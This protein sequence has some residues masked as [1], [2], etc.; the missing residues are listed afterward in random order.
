MTPGP[1]LHGWFTATARRSP[2]R[3]AVNEPGREPITYAR[4]EALSG[5]V[6]DR[7]LAEGL[8]PGD[9]VGIYLTKSVDA[10]AA[11][12]GALR[13][14]AA[15]VPIDPGSPAW[16]ADFILNDCAVQALV[17]ERRFLDGLETLRAR[18][19]PPVVIALDEV[20]DGRGLAAVLGDRRVPGGDDA[21][22]EADALAYILYTSGSTGKP[23]GVMVSHRAAM[24][25]VDW[26]SRAFSPVPDDRFSSHAPF[27]FDLSIL[28]LYLPLRH[29]ARVTLIG[30]QLGKDPMGLADL[31]ATE[32]LTVW[33]ST[34]SILALLT[35]HG[36]LERHDLR[37][38]RLILFA[39]EVFP[40]PALRELT[41]ALPWPR[42][43]NLFGPTETNVCTWYEAQLPIPSDRTE[44]LPI[45]RPCDHYTARVEDAE[46]GA[47]DRGD[48]GELLIAGPGLMSG[49]W[50]L[51]ERNADAFWVDP[52][53]TRWYRTGDLVREGPD[54]DFVFHGRRDRM[55]KRR[56]YRIELGEI[57]AGL[58]RHPAVRE[59]AVVAVPDPKSG[60]R[61]RAFLAT[62][63]GQRLSVIE[64]KGFCAAQLPA[65]MVPDGF[66]F[67]PALPRT[68]TDKVDYQRLTT[69]A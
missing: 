43:F 28:D 52:Q 65:Y 55:V 5:A 38:L 45:G 17:V 37:T 9:R 40:I 24:S 60:V 4:L 61:I 42:F 18:E 34:P 15:Y 13:A 8:R 57:E 23:K 67:L 66:A 14:G 69:M 36:R 54:G 35:K 11:L 6:R 30:D 27:H 29:G 33:Y 50:N 25:F 63:E 7:L 22:P 58:V 39:G 46:G 51:P 49:Y 16:R 21:A 19:E 2:E 68:S 64:L 26:C 32:R 31:I 62:S 56:G 48:V 12:L 53:G 1:S 59:V 10:L 47:V 41:T 44:P 20:G 3:P